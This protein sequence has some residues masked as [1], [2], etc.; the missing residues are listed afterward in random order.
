MCLYS[1]TELSTKARALKLQAK[2]PVLCRLTNNGTNSVHQLPTGYDC[3]LSNFSRTFS[4]RFGKFHKVTDNLQT[5]ARI[6]SLYSHKN[7]IVLAVAKS[8]LMNLEDCFIE[9]KI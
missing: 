3:H 5:R 6:G 8:Y 2:H 9:G 1:G 7:Y 4:E